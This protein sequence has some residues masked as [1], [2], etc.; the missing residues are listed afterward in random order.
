MARKQDN[1]KSL[2][3]LKAP[4]PK[5]ISGN[6]SG[7]PRKPI[8]DAYADLAERNVPNDRK[9]RTYA[10]LLAQAQFHA[11]IKGKTEAAKE[12]ANRIE[13]P[14]EKQQVEIIQ[15]SEPLKVRFDAPDLVTALR[16]I[17]GLSSPGDTS[18]PAEAKPVPEEMDRG[19]QPSED[20]CKG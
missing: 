11:A 17:Y 20:S 18:R 1:P 10:E 2:K 6:P 5:G 19:P 15:G 4:W 14:A 16:A 8:S 9:R 7:R 3:N 12:I 13:G